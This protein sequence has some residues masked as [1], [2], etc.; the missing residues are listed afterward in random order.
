MQK[1]LAMSYFFICCSFGVS[2]FAQRVIS[3]VIFDNNKEILPGVVVAVKENNKNATSSDANG[4][5][6]ISLPDDGKYYTL[7]TSFMGFE[8]QHKK[9]SSQKFEKMDIYLT[10]DN[11]ELDVIV[12]TGTRTPKLLKNT[13]II[14]KVITEQ[15]IKKV[16]ATHIG[17]LLQSELPGIEFSYS[18]NQQVSLNMQGF[19]GNSVLFLVDGERQAGETLDNI[20]YS[21]LNLDN[22]ERVEI[23]KGAAS[24][25]YGSS[26]LGGVVNIISKNTTE[27][28]TLNLNTKLAAHNSQRY[29][30]SA[31]FNIG[32][33]SSLTNVQHTTEDGYNM[34]NEGDFNSVLGS[35]TWS[36]KERLQYTFNDQISFTGRAG[37][38]FRERASSDR[39]RDYSAGLKGNYS[40]NKQNGVELAYS[41]DQ[42]DKS[43]YFQS[44]NKDIRDYSNVQN[45]LKGLYYHAFDEDNSLIV[46]GDYMRDYLMS[47]QFKD[48]KSYHQYIADGFAQL[49]LKPLDKF[50]LI[51][52]LRYDYFSDNSV[53]HFTSSLATMYK[54][55]NC[56][57]RGSYAGGFRAPSLKEM[58]MAFDMASVF[59]IYGNPNLKP[60]TSQNLMISTEYTNKY[61]NLS[62]SGFYNLVDNRITTA[63][64]QDLKGQVYTNIKELTISGIDINASAKFPCGVGARFSY[65]YTHEDIEKGQP[66]I[67]ST[68]PHTATARLEYGKD[69]NKYGFNVMLNGRFL[70]KVSTDQYTSITS[71]DQ[72]EKVS[73]PAYTI[74]KLS[75]LQ[76]IS[77]GIDLT[78]AVDNIFNYIPSYNYDNSPV[79]TGATFSAGISIDLDKFFKK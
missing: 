36:F 59:M 29:G 60:E 57:L 35:R 70:S 22:V 51:A 61:Y 63:W 9:T 55:G 16:D 47:Y 49:D 66:Q 17:E 41:F 14:T 58:Y 44:L 28:W 69:W 25:L 4:Y 67:S 18:M 45:I 21:R 12:V 31:G 43:D 50:N 34:K 7:Q 74:W 23:I 27:P 3:G 54:V 33:L 11:I 30:G 1:I 2:C 13:P 15:D 26:A 32:K 72:T 71:Y 75:L 10:E 76:K 19:G 78:M 53:K 38:F 37:Y 68:R 40:I 39:Y 5:Y 48:N 77:K 73:Y 46:G 24:T 6:T 79:T 64:D 20:D 52:G 42:Y 65:I 56:S 8:P 62:V